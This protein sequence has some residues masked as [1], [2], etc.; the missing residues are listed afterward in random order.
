[1]RSH[2][3]TGKSRGARAFLPVGDRPS[4]AVE[5]VRNGMAFHARAEEAPYHKEVKN[6]TS[7]GASLPYPI[8]L[9]SPAPS[10]KLA[11]LPE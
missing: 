11:R 9:W 2:H 4:R 3:I 5:E 10:A 1:M 7:S 6:A 8:H